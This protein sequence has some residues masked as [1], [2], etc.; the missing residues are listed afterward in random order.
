M[1]TNLDENSPS[2]IVAATPLTASKG[3]AN[4]SMSV[5]VAD[6]VTEV[7]YMMGQDPQPFIFEAADVNSDNDID[8]LD[9]VGTVNIIQAPNGVEGTSVASVVTYTVRDG[10][11]YV[12][13][14][15]DLGG[16]QVQLTARGTTQFETLEAL[17]GFEH[18]GSW[19]QDSTEYLFLAFSLTGKTLNAGEHALLRIGDADIER[20]IFSD[21]AGKNVIGI[22]GSVTGVGSVLGM[23]MRLP[24]PNPFDEQLTVPYVISGDGAQSVR[25]NVVD[26]GGRTVA[27][28]RATHTYGEYIHTFA[29][30]GLAKG[31]YFVNLYVNDTLMQTAKAIK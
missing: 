13:S 25:I 28:F 1:T 7:G 22:N 15:V 12:D 31:I 19:Q 11:L 26:L 3:D 17:N 27:T 14:P 9:V 8:V 6:V 20:I 16:V 4:G 10:V 29:T 2:K 5:D 24:Y 23:Q 18:V 30:S 21:A